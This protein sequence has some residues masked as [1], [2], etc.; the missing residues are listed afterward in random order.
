MKDMDEASYVLGIRISRDSQA[1]E[2][3]WDKEKSKLGKNGMQ[4]PPK[5]LKGILKENQAPHDQQ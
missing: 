3:G 5:L 4:Y 1:A 2:I